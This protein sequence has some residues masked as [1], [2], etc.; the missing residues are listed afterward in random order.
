MTDRAMLRLPSLDRRKHVPMRT[1]RAIAR[2]IA[3]QFDPEK[4]ILFGSYAYGRPKP[5][6]D[7]DLLVVMDTP[8]GEWPINKAIRLAIPPYPFSVDI[9]VR[10]QAMIDHRVAI[11]D[12]FMREIVTKGK[13]LYE[14]G[15]GRM[16]R[17]SRK[18]LQITRFGSRTGWDYNGE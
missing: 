11:N 4:I 14:R 17:K 7:V 6:S 9:L 5:W 3:E 15:N 12:W 1:I 8:E 16:G 10:S 13:V 2:L 18:R